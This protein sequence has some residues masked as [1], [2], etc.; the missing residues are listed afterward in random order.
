MVTSRP[1]AIPLANTSA[2]LL[3]ACWLLAGIP[4]A[5]AAAGSP[6]GAEA[7]QPAPAPTPIPTSEI[8]PAIVAVTLDLERIRATAVPT[9]EA[10]A[11]ETD[12]P[13]R[14]EELSAL[15]DQLSEEHIEGV[16]RLS[17]LDDLQ[18]V[19][20][21]R[22]EALDEWNRALSRDL[23]RLGESLSELGAL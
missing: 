9:S 8:G 19:W 3:A 23:K 14:S 22:N 12:L 21:R 5:I 16:V 13:E 17:T 2:T 4:A 7:A 20:T 10:A 18:R 11:I 15:A 1:V 6:E